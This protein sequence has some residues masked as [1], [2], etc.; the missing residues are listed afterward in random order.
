M[1]FVFEPLRIHWPHPESFQPRGI[2]SGIGMCRLTLEC[3][4]GSREDKLLFGQHLDAN[5]LLD[6][7]YRGR[8]HASA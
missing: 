7:F 1:R 2:L 8:I 4:I 5:K 6:P 3:N